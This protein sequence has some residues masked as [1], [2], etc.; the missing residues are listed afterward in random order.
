MCLFFYVFF[1]KF[2]SA[3]IHVNIDALH[4][5]YISKLIYY[6]KGDNT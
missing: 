6:A 3:T 2:I 5:L 4:L 1:A